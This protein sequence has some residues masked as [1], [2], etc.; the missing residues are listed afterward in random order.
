MKRNWTL[1]LRPAS[2]GMAIAV[3]FLLGDST[4][5][6]LVGARNSSLH[7]QSEQIKLRLDSLA[8]V[9]ESL[10]RRLLLQTALVEASSGR[11]PSKQALILADE[12][13]RNA[14]L[15]RFDPL[16]ILAVVITESEGNTQ[17]VGRFS[18]GT[19]SGAVG[20]MQVRPATARQT[21]QRMGIVVPD[22][23]GLLDPAFNLTVGVA[24]LLQMIHRYGDLRLGIMA[25]NVGPRALESGLRGEVSLPEGYYRK[26]LRT[27]RKL[28]RMSD[29]SHP[30]P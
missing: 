21:A 20:V 10:Q 28:S 2:I 4:L 23:G 9:R 13:D 1:K 15:Y 8:Q 22:S 18:S 30:A 17:A 6:I 16:L 14:R 29:R 5:A 25:Y 12:I 11:I 7:R 19:A 3:A 27:Y 24:Y 26:V